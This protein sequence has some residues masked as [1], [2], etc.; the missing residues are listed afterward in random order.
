MEPQLSLK[1]YFHLFLRCKHFFSTALLSFLL[2]LLVKVNVSSTNLNRKY[3]LTLTYYFAIFSYAAIMFTVSYDYCLAPRSPCIA[4]DGLWE[5]KLMPTVRS[6]IYLPLFSSGYG[7]HLCPVDQPFMELRA[8]VR[9]C[10]KAQVLAV[11]NRTNMLDHPSHSSL[12]LY[13][14]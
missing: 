3:Y 13:L 7:Q 11:T 1:V 5:A 6:S 12:S 8:H 9:Y 10:G 4:M 14:P 2:Q